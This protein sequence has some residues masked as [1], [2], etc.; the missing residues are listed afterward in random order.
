MSSSIFRDIELKR[1]RSAQ[2]F[3]ARKERWLAKLVRFNGNLRVPGRPGY[4]YAQQLPVDD[5]PPPVPVLCISVQARENLRVWIEK[6][7]EGEWEVVSWWKGIT[8]QGDYN[9]QAYLPLHGPDHEW[10]DR[11]PRVD[12]VNIYP[13]ALTMLRAYPSEGGGI[14]VAVSPLRYV[15]NGA[16]IVYP[17]EHTVDLSAS[18]P[19]AGQARYVGVYL[20]LATNSVGSVDGATTIDAAPV[21]PASPTFPD[22]CITS[23]MVRLD[24]DQTA[25]SEADFVDLRNWLGLA[26]TG[27]A[28]DLARAVVFEGA[29]VTNAEEIVWI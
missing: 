18:Q 14:N 6:N 15:L 22:D 17:G 1:Q 25:F 5:A 24:G 9:L 4:V 10:P 23:A 19:A 28:G 21:N 12:A 11:K 2:Q 29:V 20:D 3:E 16:V 13:R 27:G 26:D 7:Y 8:Q